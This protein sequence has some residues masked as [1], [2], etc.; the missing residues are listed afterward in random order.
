MKSLNYTIV[1]AITDFQLALVEQVLQ[2]FVNQ[3][4]PMFIKQPEIKFPISISP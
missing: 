3:P 1:W 2:D 4:L